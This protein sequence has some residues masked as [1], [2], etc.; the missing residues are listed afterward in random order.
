MS[1]I[2]KNVRFEMIKKEQKR[3]VEGAKHNG[4]TG[5]E[6]TDLVCSP[7]DWNSPEVLKSLE[8]KS[9]AAGRQNGSEALLTQGFSK[10]LERH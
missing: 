1:L 7:L 6:T 5:C 9:R 8:N 2:L 10:I 3:S 4:C